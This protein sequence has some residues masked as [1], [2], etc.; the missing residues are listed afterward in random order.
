MKTS[1][2]ILVLLF[3]AA[4][5]MYAQEDERIVIGAGSFTVKNGSATTAVQAGYYF[6]MEA[7]QFYE[8]GGELQYR[9]MKATVFDVPGVEITS[10]SIPCLLTLK[11]VQPPVVPYAGIGVIFGMSSFEKS[12]VE[13][14]RPGL[15]VT[16]NLAA[17]YGFV[18]AG[19]LR[20]HLESGV[21]FFGEYRYGW[22]A[23]SV[24][25]DG[26]ESSVNQG[27]SWILGGLGVQ[28]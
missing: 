25:L 21:S 7:G 24:S 5:E 20:V 28:L 16:D 26:N 18:L 9:T 19:G 23:F 14:R 4:E 22:D 17:S 15:V 1:I 2:A 27:G 3:G 13:S 6:S 11:V 8:M 10:F 12:Y